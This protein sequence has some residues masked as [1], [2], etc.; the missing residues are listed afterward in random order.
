MYQIELSV[1]RTG[2]CV[3]KE[4]TEPF[5]RFEIPRNATFLGEGTIGSNALPG[6]GVNVALFAGEMGDGKIVF[7]FSLVFSPVGGL[8]YEREGDARCLA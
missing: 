4:L 2:K 1:N 5:H 3:K 8:P 6:L 7:S